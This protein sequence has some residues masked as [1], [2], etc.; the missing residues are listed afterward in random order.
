M[1][2]TRSYE[3]SAELAV[4]FVGLRLRTPV[5]AGSAGITGTV[6]GMK[7]SEDAGAGAI[8]MKSLFAKEVCR[9]APTPRFRVLRQ[10]SGRERSFALYSYEQASEWGPDRYAEEV[11]RAKEAL[12]IPIIPSI[13]CLTPEQWLD[14]SA[15]MEEA[16]ADAVELNLSCPHGPHLMEGHDVT[17]EMIE[18][19]RLVKSARSIP[20]IPKMTPQLNNP[21]GVAV[22]LERAGADAIVAFNRFTGLDI[23][24]ETERPVMHGG[25]AGH[26][27][28]WSLYYT[29][30]W[31]T[32]IYPAV[33]VPLSMSGGLAT[34]QDVVKSILAGATVT[35][36]VTAVVMRGYGEITRFNEGLARWMG[37]KG[38][39]GISDFRGAVCS[40]IVP[41]EEVFRDH[42]LRA[43]I[44]PAECTACGLCERVC[45]YDAA[46]ES[47]GAYAVLAER[48]DGCGL[49]VEV[50]PV[51]AISMVNR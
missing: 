42:V 11:R 23:D 27:G 33:T 35:Q 47:D 28:P 30:R 5:I 1:S 32:A 40:R 15:L 26:G 20:V 3:P 51:G 14:Y 38:H 41:M 49:C 36:T 18:M 4:D 37:E 21:P 7:R 6:E 39:T 50:C 16:G 48:C 44:A 8:V 24:I 19:T 10:A 29:L 45:I 31:L 22:A 34:W 43:T 25:Y 13:N 12:A 17:R 2:A 46:V 9:V